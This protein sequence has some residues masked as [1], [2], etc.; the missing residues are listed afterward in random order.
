MPLFVP[1]LAGIQSHSVRNLL[2]KGSVFIL[3]TGYHDDL[4]VNK[5]TI[6]FLKDNDKKVYVVNT[7][8]IIDIYN[9]LS[10]IDQV[11]ALIHST[12]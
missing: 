7:S 4:G 3:T 6:K 1:P 10:K 12:C 8:N 5:N 11:V 2:N 9:D